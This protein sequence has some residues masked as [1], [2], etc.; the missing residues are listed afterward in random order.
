MNSQADRSASSQDNNINIRRKRSIRSRVTNNL[1]L[2]LFA[3]VISLVLFLF[4]L[5][6]RNTT[7]KFEKIPVDIRVPEGFVSLANSTHTTVDVTV[8]GRASLL[9][10]FKRDDIGI[11][12]L[13]APARDGNI[14]VTLQSGMLSLPE[15]VKIDKFSPEFIGLDLEKLEKRT[16]AIS[17]DHA[18]TG[19]LLPG[20][21]LGEVKIQPPE[22]EISGPSS[23][24]AETSQLYI[25]PIDL[26][27][28]AATFSVNRWVI[29]NRV[30]LNAQSPQVMVT[31][32]IVSKSKFHVVRG[33]PI[34]PVNLSLHYEFVPSTIDLTL[35]GDEETLAKIDTSMLFVTV[36]AENDNNTESNTRLLTS[37]DITVSNLPSDVALDESKLP[38]VLFRVWKNAEDRPSDVLDEGNASDNS[39]ARPNIPNP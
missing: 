25:E 12:T 37:R 27:G 21:Q 10:S 28:K 29:L 11:I 14:Q 1:P 34:R 6:D 15:G 19:E 22:V 18:F 23:L 39:E 3:L 36:D 16:V 17:T 9:R 31:V 7:L 32:N 20:Y 8:H 30:G 4:V 2:K 13:N 5:G 26:T 24:I 33:V 38:S 35:V